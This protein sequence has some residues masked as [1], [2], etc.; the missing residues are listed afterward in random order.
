MLFPQAA[1]WLVFMGSMDV[2][3]TQLVLGL[4][5]REVNPIALAVIESWGWAGATAFK[6]AT[7]LLALLATEAVGRRKPVV[8]RRLAW[9]LV[10]LA[11]FPVVWSLILLWIQ[12]TTGPPPA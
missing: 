11:G 3:L 12:A 6:F 1:I 2:M 4:G 8:G 7:V 5:G 9:V 10:A